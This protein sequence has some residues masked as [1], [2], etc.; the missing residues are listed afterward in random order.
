MS[1]NGLHESG[2]SGRRLAVGVLVGVV[3]TFAVYGIY[4]LYSITGYCVSCSAGQTVRS[5]L[6]LLAWAAG[7][8]IA[9]ALS[10][11]V[12]GRSEVLVA[13]GSGLLGLVLLGF[14]PGSLV[15]PLI[16]VL[17]SVPFLL[18]VAFGGELIRTRRA[19]AR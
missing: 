15:S 6:T 1:D 5:V 18:L 11:V 4:Y 14:M 12:A 8:F 2:V 17:S 10:G 16:L 9:G 19:K 13:G 3:A 7:A